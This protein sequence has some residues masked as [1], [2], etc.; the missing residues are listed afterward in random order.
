MGLELSR[1]EKLQDERRWL[2]WRKLEE[3]RE[4]AELKRRRDSEREY[5][6]RERNR[7]IYEEYDD[8]MKK[9]VFKRNFF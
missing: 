7:R 1:V 6:E 2:E 3:E 8:Q 4:M 9:S 5:E